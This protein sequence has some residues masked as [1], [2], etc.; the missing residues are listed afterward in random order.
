MSSAG[1]AVTAA[2]LAGLFGAAWVAL[3]YAWHPDFVVDFDRDYPR[4]SPGSTRPSAIAASDLTFAWTSADAVVR[5]PGLDRRVEWTLD[6]RV[7]AA[8]PS[9]PDNP[10][11]TILVD[12]IASNGAGR[13][14]AISGSCTC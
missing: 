3:L 13:R 9:L 8:R 2:I 1:R 10:D 12:G 7:R 14:R 6:V 5:L 4:N 11:L